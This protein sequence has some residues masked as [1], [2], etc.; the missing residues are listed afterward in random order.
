MKQLKFLMIAFTFL[1]GISLTSCLESGDSESAYD[2]G[3][4][5]FV[6][7]G[8][9][10]T[11]F[12]EDLAGNKLYPSIASITQI[13]A[14]GFKVSDYGLAI[15]YIKLIDKE[16]TPKADVPKSYEVNLVS[17]Q[18]CQYN[19]SVVAQ[20]KEEM[21]IIAPE[22]APIVSLALNNGYGG[23]A[24]PFLLTKEVVLLPIAW[25]LEKNDKSIIEK[26]KLVLVSSMVEVES[27]STDLVLYLRHDKGTD[28]KTDVTYADFYGYNISNAVEQ[29]K[30]KAGNAPTKVIIKAH[31]T[32]Q[33]GGNEIPKNYTE[34]P[35]E[36]KT[37]K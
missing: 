11:V 24:K 12:F 15:I 34:Y 16:A 2:W 22:T 33:N 26:H 28:D 29:F 10:G 36:Y 14:G 19:R 25:K 35:L 8:S 1:M 5:V 32:G 7:G 23:Q 30:M 37:E 9:L 21:E 4:Y 18:G 31:E 17:F 6:K 13:E 20:N 3:G 27:G